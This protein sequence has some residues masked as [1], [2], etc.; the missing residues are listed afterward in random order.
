[1]SPLAESSVSL[2]V[3]FKVLGSRDQEALQ[4]LQAMQAQ[5]RARHAGLSARL[6]SRFDTPDDAD[7]TWMEVYERSEGLGNAFF[8][9]LEALVSSLPPRL[10]GPR[11]TEAFCEI[12]PQPT[13]QPQ[14]D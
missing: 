9:D 10:L 1:M 7:P 11:H 5:L 4:R 14:G 2:F 8:E 13:V 12:R 3:Y 6:L